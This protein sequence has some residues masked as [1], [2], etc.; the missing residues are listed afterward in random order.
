MGGSD[1]LTPSRRGVM[2]GAAASVAATAIPADAQSARKQDMA[3]SRT[4]NFTVN[5]ERRTLGAIHVYLEAGRFRQTDFDFIIAVANL[6][7]AGRVLQDK[8][9][10]RPSAGSKALSARLTVPVRQVEAFY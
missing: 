4:V 5:G 2:I 7:A 10:R 9:N 1:G 6:V 3:I 8:T